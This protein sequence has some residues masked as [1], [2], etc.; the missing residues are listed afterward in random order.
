MNSSS[1]ANIK[2]DRLRYSK[3]KL[4]ANLTILSIVFNA[5][6]FISIYKSDV[7]SYYYT[8]L[9]GISIVYNLLFMLI[10]FLASEGVKS[11]KINY[12]FVLLA[13]GIG[14]IIRIFIMPVN[15]HNAVVTLSQEAQQVMHDGQF[16]RVC[17]Y[18]IASAALSILAGITAFVK[19]R[20]LKSYE[21]EIEE[22][23]RGASH[24]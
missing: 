5:L 7:G 14:Q 16:Y 9:I 15:A 11:Y 23:T 10:S 1:I 20:T 13:L 4:S 19:T 8:Y 6:Y 2:K 21:A 22:M 17:F 24:E 18:L 12:S 3:N